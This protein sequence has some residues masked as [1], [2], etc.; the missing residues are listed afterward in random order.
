[1]ICLHVAMSLDFSSIF[2]CTRNNS[3]YQCHVTAN[4]NPL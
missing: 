1:M 2:D 3:I 4:K